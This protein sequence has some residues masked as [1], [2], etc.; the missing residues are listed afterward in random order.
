MKLSWRAAAVVLCASLVCTVSLAR[1]DSLT[2][3]TVTATLLVP[4]LLGSATATIGAFNPTFPVGSI[5]GNTPFYINITSDQIFYYPN[6]NA[7]YGVSSFNGF[8]F[9]FSGAPKIVNVTLDA[10]S[11]FTPTNITFT[12]NSISLN[13]SGDTVTTSSVLILDIRLQ[14]S[15]ETPEPSTALTLGTSLVGLLGAA[16]WKH[17]RPASVG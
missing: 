8:V 14:N 17:Y 12:S 7:T 4:G 11:T 13:L 10:A 9:N 1:A 6:A 3:S 2:G 5:M 16:G 15:V